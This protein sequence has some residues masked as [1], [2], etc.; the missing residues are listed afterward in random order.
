LKTF[1]G[2]ENE[3][4]AFERYCALRVQERSYL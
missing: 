1:V 3:K 4:R 2:L